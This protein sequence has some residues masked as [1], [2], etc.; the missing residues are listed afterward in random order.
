LAGANAVNLHQI[1]RPDKNYDFI[2]CSHVIDSVEGP[3][4][5]T[6]ELTRVLSDTGLMFLSYPSPATRDVTMDWGYADLSRGGKCRIFGCDFEKNI[7]DT[8]PQA[9]FT[10][11]GANDPVTGDA[12]RFYVVT[13][14]PNWVRQIFQLGFDAEL[15]NFVSL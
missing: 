6:S 3:Q 15:I 10:A 4:R 9:L 7:K 8:V 11:V 1:D 14:S 13:K 12:D 5:A 2:V